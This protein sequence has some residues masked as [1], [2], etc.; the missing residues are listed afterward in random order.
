[1][2]RKPKILS[3]VSAPGEELKHEEIKCDL[4]CLS[5]KKDGCSVHGV[6]T[7]KKTYSGV[8]L[9]IIGDDD[10]TKDVVMCGLN[11][12]FIKTSGLEISGLTKMKVGEVAKILIN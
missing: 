1:M 3:E 5:I 4:D 2:G 8:V 12:D 10:P 11:K 6:F 9:F 7:I